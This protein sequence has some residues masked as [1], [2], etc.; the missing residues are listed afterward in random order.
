[1]ATKVKFGIFLIG[2]IS[3]IGL[4]SSVS[5]PHIS[6]S[7]GIGVRTTLHECNGDSNINKNIPKN[8]ISKWTAEDLWA[9]STSQNL[10]LDGGAIVL[11]GDILIEDDAAGIGSIRD[12]A[13]DTLSVGTV[14]RKYLNIDQAPLNDAVI[15]MMLYPVAPTEPL[16]GGKLE[17]AINGRE[18]IIYE[19]RHFWTSVTVPA[20]YL[21]AGENVI[22]VRV[23]SKENRYRIPVALHSNFKY[24][25]TESAPR[26]SRSERSTDNGKTW[27]KYRLRGSD[28]AGGEYPIRIKLKEYNERAWLQTPVINLAES[29]VLLFPVKIDLAAVIPDTVQ[30]QGSKWRIRIRMGN[31]HQPE[32]GGWSDWE[33][34]QGNDLSK[35]ASRFIQLEFS[36]EQNLKKLSPKLTGLQVQSRWHDESTDLRKRM[37]V[38]EV[39]N[40]PII[41]GSFAFEHEDPTLAQLQ[42]FRKK[43]ELDKVVAG[44]L[45]EWEKIRKLR[46]WVARRWDWYLPNSNIEDFTTWNA[47]EILD[48]SGASQKIG[49]NCLH[50]AIVLTQACQSFG[51]PAR[52]V[53]TNFS[54]W[55]GHELVEVWSRDYEKWIMVDPNFDTMFYYRENAIPL[56][57]LELHK[58]FLDTY[59]PDK[60]IINRDSWSAA[61]RDN[62]SDRIDPALLP[63]QM[64]VGGNAYSGKIKEDYVW[65]KVKL[66]QSNPGYSGGYGFFNTA[67]VR[68]L[69]RSNWLSRPEPNPITHGR[70]HWGWDGYYIWTDAQTPETPEHRH[71]VRRDSDM[72]GKLHTVDL[73]AEAIGPDQLRVNLATVGPGFSHFE[74]IENGLRKE[75]NKS[76]FLWNLVPGIN[77]LEVRSVDK[78][79][80]KGSASTLKINLVPGLK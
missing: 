62:R 63:I 35:I 24:G 54:I 39:S 34:L 30:T 13:W 74:V 21:K 80:N 5:M 25:T 41:P 68:W 46:G 27:T 9:Q 78:L 61:D 18:P 36:F 33:V 1:M 48:V 67:E 23:H 26:V 38:S 6:E 52:I 14:V 10:K 45:T 57:A 15:T 66:E 7:E 4:K 44:S 43:F 32:L 79:G 2:L 70:T 16:N 59:Y 60:E 50:Y 71:Y 49:G 42:D 29:G 3:F 53:S 77:S 55:G 11:Q 73:S 22:D 12:G 47:S 56:S 37:L 75:I 65:W 19:V 51:I 20:H 17:F 28:L 72:Y 40:K 31:K 76:D 58:V 8:K 69:P 64:E